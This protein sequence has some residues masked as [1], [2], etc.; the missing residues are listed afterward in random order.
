MR[1]KPNNIEEVLHEL[2]LR[3]VEDV[4]YHK[5]GKESS[6]KIHCNLC[7][8]WLSFKKYNSAYPDIAL[9]T[10]PHFSG[11][12]LWVRTYLRMNEFLPEVFHEWCQ[13]DLDRKVMQEL[14]Q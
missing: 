9:S 13:G 7:D 14:F 2:G 4:L 10:A 3:P 5:D 6:V 12:I 1:P 8:L 11:R